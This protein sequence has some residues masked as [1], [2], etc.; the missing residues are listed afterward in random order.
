MFQSG[1]A[2]YEQASLIALV[3]L[4]LRR[5]EFHEVATFYRTE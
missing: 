4:Y 5:R 3:T 1:S 2:Q